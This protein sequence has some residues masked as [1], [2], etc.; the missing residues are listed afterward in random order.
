MLQWSSGANANGPLSKSIQ[1]IIDPP[2]QF[3]K[4]RTRG[5]RMPS[6]FHFGATRSSIIEYVFRNNMR[7]RIISP[8][9]R[10]S[11]NAVSSTSAQERT[12]VA[13]GAS[14]KL[15][16]RRQTGQKRF[17]EGGKGYD[18]SDYPSKLLFLYL[19]TRVR[20]LCIPYLLR[21]WS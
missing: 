4:I 19:G 8:S 11:L 17:Q 3:E 14:G 16:L 5:A 10:S 1:S 15:S 9:H 2:N 21:N 18:R 6:C 13:K 12:R 7:R 20:F